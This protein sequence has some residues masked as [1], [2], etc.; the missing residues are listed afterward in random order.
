MQ[1]AKLEGNKIVTVFQVKNISA[2]RSIVGLQISEFWYDKAGNLCRAP[3]TV[4]ACGRR[5]SPAKW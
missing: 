4:S 1:S 3:A 5:C 2:D